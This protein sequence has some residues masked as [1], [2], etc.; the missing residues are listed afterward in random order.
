MIDNGRFD[1]RAL[2]SEPSAVLLDIWNCCDRCLDPR[3][4]SASRGSRAAVSVAIILTP[5]AALAQVTSLSEA[6]YW[7]EAKSQQLVRQS[8]SHD[9][10]G[11]SAFIPQAG[12][13][14][15]AF[16]L[17]DYAYMLEGCPEAFTTQEMKDSLLTFVGG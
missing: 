8:R 15:Q 12:G 13:G 3:L 11:T 2:R 17:R 10:N 4:V 14:Y 7:L 5:W 1:H 16:W 9:D 6:T